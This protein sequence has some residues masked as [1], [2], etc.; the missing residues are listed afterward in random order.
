[1][2]AGFPSRGS[3]YN[4]AAVTVAARAAART[5]AAVASASA[6]YLGCSSLRGTT[7]IINFQGIATC[8]KI[9]AGAAAA[10]AA[11]AAAG[12]A[13]AGVVFAGQCPWSCVCAVINCSSC[14]TGRQQQPV[15]QHTL[16]QCLQ[17]QQQQRQPGQQHQRRFAKIV[18]W[19]PDTPLAYGLETFKDAEDFFKACEQNSGALLLLILLLKLLQVLMLLWVLLFLVQYQGLLLLLLLPPAFW[20]CQ[21]G[22]YDHSGFAPYKYNHCGCCCFRYCCCR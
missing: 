2:T 22:D 15:L 3:S 14:V 1:M 10:R 7:T 13:T 18:R 16:Q 6:R 19:S 21:S 5:T 20:P 8:S 9:A 4:Y 11:T 12:A 17:P